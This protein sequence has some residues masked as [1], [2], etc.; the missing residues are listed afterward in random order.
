[1]DLH[2]VNIHILRVYVQQRT[3]ACNIVG[4]VKHSN[5]E[6]TFWGYIDLYQK[7]NERSGERDEKKEKKKIIK[8]QHL[9]VMTC[10]GF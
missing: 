5:S 3:H 4:Y 9:L 8:E 1:M 6:S 10:P 7:K 2:I